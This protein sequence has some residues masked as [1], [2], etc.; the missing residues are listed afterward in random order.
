M[1]SRYYSAMSLMWDWLKNSS[2]FKIKEH[3][4]KWISLSIMFL[5][6][7]SLQTQF[8]CVSINDNSLTCVSRLDIIF[9]NFYVKRFC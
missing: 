7:I 1:S 6:E 4:H 5:V 9:N 2:Y 3:N 8:L